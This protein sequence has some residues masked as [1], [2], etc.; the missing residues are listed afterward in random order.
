MKKLTI[1]AMSVLSVSMILPINAFAVSTIDIFTPTQIILQ[2]CP[3]PTG[4]ILIV[5][6]NPIVS[7]GR[8]Y[9]YSS[10]GWVEGYDDID[11]MIRAPNDMTTYMG[12]LGVP[13]TGENIIVTNPAAGGWDM[14]Y[15]TYSISASDQSGATAGTPKASAFEFP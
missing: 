9:L 8:E 4:W 10:I 3:C 14:W 7:A 15:K 6:N 1:F 2:G 5:N 12:T 13:Q 11:L